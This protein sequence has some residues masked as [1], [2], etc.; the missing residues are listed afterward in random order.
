[1]LFLKYVVS[2]QRGIGSAASKRS[3]QEL[4]RRFTRAQR[5]PRQVTS[6][7]QQQSLRPE[8]VSS[9][10]LAL[11]NAL[12]LRGLVQPCAM[13]LRWLVA[14]GR[15]GGLILPQSHGPVGSS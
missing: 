12:V 1:M 10:A 5:E 6:T 7:I 3:A 9:G 11:C 15:E 13:T 2:Q 8:D 14:D 4:R